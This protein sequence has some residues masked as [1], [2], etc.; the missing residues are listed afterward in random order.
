MAGSS[1]DPKPA[2]P[3]SLDSSS[4]IQDG[5]GYRVRLTG[6]MDA[7]WIR[8]YIAAWT[9]LKF[10]SRFQ[11]DV[12]NQTVWFALEKT[13][14]PEDV[15]SVLAILAAMLRLTGGSTSESSRLQ[16]RNRLAPAAELQLP[17]PAPPPPAL[18]LPR[19]SRND[20]VEDLGDEEIDSLISEDLIEA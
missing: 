19:A 3:V 15:N 6:S 16:R 12:A 5:A 14:S 7:T 1:P 2:G 8:S 20:H 10:F 4:V 9:G 11:L 18:D 17:L 13:E